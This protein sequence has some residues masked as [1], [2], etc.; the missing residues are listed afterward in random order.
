[1]W[2]WSPPTQEQKQAYEDCLQCCFTSTPRQDDPKNRVYEWSK[3]GLY[4]SLEGA[5]FKIVY[6]GST[7]TTATGC[8][9]GSGIA[10]LEFDEF[11]DPYV[12]GFLWETTAIMTF[13]ANC[14]G[15]LNETPQTKK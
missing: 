9:T 15:K 13:K 14:Q 5:G 4:A 8:A 11:I 1:M 2:G 10:T 12:I 3:I 7:A 6:Q